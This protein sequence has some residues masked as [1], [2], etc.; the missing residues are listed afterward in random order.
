ML[1]R[2]DAAI[3]HARSLQ[4]STIVLIGHGTGAYW[5]SQYLAQLQPKDVGQLVVIDPRAPLAA[6]QPLERYL[7]TRPAATADSYTGTGAAANQQALP[8]R[9]AARRAGPPDERLAPPPRLTNERP[10][11]QDTQY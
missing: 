1:A 5:A 7:A 3:E 2:L 11:D 9:H 4:A 10:H 8:R 6:E